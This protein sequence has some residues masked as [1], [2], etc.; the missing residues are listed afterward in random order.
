MHA[1]K[2]GTVPSRAT[3]RHHV[4]PRA[5]CC[6]HR[7][8]CAAVRPARG[9]R[10]VG[11][12]AD[13]LVV[14]LHGL[15]EG[16]SSHDFNDL[17][18]AAAALELTRAASVLAPTRRADGGPPPPPRTG[19]RPL[20]RNGEAEGQPTRRVARFR[21]AARGRSRSALYGC[22]SDRR[23]RGDGGGRRGG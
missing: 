5:A 9:G 14:Y 20:E 17:V 18:N 23:W 12:S 6:G 8:P 2:L 21:A 13:P 15:D 22:G 16:R 11:D 7:T 4:P 1:I 3:P 10:C 19:A